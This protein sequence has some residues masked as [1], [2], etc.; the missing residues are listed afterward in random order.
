M[1]SAAPRAP[2][3]VSQSAMHQHLTLEERREPADARR[4]YSQV[5][6]CVRLKTNGSLTMSQL[7]LMS[8]SG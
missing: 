3:V 4:G 7:G 2:F 1:A 8:D 6:A 5:L